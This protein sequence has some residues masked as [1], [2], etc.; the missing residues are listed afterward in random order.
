MK[1]NHAC[2]G[3]RDPSAEIIM[4]HFV[5]PPHLSFLYM[6]YILTLPTGKLYE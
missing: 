2:S 1:G 3:G 4:M 6:I 5:N